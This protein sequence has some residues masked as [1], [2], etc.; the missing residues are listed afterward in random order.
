MRDKRERSTPLYL[1]LVVYALI[2]AVWII[3]SSRHLEIIPWEKLLRSRIYN[4]EYEDEESLVNILMNPKNSRISISSHTRAHEFNKEKEHALKAPHFDMHSCDAGNNDTLTFPWKTPTF[5]IIGQHKCGTT[6]LYSIL[7]EHPNLLP[8]TKFEPHY[9]D[10]KGKYIE[11][12]I[13]EGPG[14]KERL[15]AERYR[16]A[17][18]NFD[19]DQIMEDPNV[20]ATF[21][22][23]PSYFEFVNDPALIK[24]VVPDTKIILILRD[25]VE[26][27]QSHLSMTALEGLS[28]KEKKAGKVNEEKLDKFLNHVYR[29]KK[30]ALH[31][32]RPQDLRRA[33]L[34]RGLYE[35]RIKK[36]L[37][38]YELGE[39]MLVLPYEDLRNEPQHVMDE[40]ADFVGFPRYDF[41]SALMEK[42]LSPTIRSRD[43]NL[44]GRK[45]TTYISDELR[46]DL[47]DLY[48][49]FNDKLADLLGER[50]RGIWGP[51]TNA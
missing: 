32:K 2:S 11:E 12:R 23:T 49:P 9:F 25:P 4:F 14:R 29:H 1:I 28:I 48:T 13:K 36:W 31:G 30:M 19:I 51:K 7:R 47:Y 50:F 26:R 27:L 5:I 10:F 38:Y 6:A 40:I 33:P 24:S 20:M 16:Y 17:T 35:Q 18:D 15:C 37:K 41:Q 8:S 34:F 21:E 43:G 45:A 44:S 46:A 22:K 39:S 42:D 3:T